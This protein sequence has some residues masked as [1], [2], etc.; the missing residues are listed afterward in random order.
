VTARRNVTH[1]LTLLSS[2]TW[3]KTMG[4]SGGYNGTVD[5]F[6]SKL[7]YGLMSYSLPQMFNISYIY[8][9]P[10]T[11]AKYFSGSKVAGGFLDGW[12]LS[13]ITNYQSGAPQP[14]S[15]G[16]TMNW[17]TMNCYEGGVLNAG[18]C[19]NY[20]ASGVG[21]YGTPDRTLYPQLLFNPQKGASRKG[22][23]SQ[24][25]NPLAITLPPVGQL[26]TTE[27]PQFL[28]P[29]SNNYDMTLFKSFKLGE[30]RRLEFRIAAF[31][32]FNRAQ[33]DT[34]A[35]DSVPNPSIN[36]MLPAGATSFTQ[37]TASTVTNAS[38]TC[39]G[40][41]TV[42]CIM[43]KHGHREMELALKFYF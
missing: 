40:G 43:S 39:S 12:Q 38:P 24:W 29:G 5:P 9:L 30:Q 17:G 20:N 13:G 4:Y 15:S 10:N 32:I 18:L 33:L 31:D 37:G 23:G 42:G 8:Q 26:G 2:Y 25:F 22:V 34:P 11:A 21:W 7:N 16:T 3:S 1:G 14:Y 41:N 27:E 19:S 28:G 36:F 35:Q 6:N